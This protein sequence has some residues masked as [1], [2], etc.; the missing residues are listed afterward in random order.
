MMFVHLQYGYINPYPSKLN[1]NGWKDLYMQWLGHVHKHT[2][3]V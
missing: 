3:K 1:Y 2:P